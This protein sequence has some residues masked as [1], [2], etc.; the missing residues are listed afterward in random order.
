VHPGPLFPP[1]PL[2]FPYRARRLREALAVGFL[3]LLTFPALVT[4]AAPGTVED[5]SAVPGW[6]LPG[7]LTLLGGLLNAFSATARPREWLEEPEEAAG[8]P[9]LRPDT[10]IAHRVAIERAVVVMHERLEENLTLTEMARRAFV[11]PYHFNRIFRQLVGIPPGQFLGALRL[12]E[13]KRLLV[14]TGLSVT[15]ICFQV[16]YSSLGTFTRRFTSLVGFCPRHFRALARRPPLP[17]SEV[18]IGPQ[19]AAQEAAVSGQIQAAD[20]FQGIAFVG[21]FD[22]PIPQG[23]PVA[24]ALAGVPGPFALPSCPDGDFHLLA[25]GL[26]PASSDLEQILFGG[27]PRGTQE[28]G[29]LRIR[30]GRA[31]RQVDVVLRQPDFIDPP[32]LITPYL[33]L[34][35]RL[36]GAVTSGP[37]RRRAFEQSRRSLPSED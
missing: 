16:G 19:P 5:L 30:D 10:V 27:M 23:A 2:A 17:W 12:Q 29:V 22:S 13:A 25:V 32:I 8:P 37:K 6:L 24:C 7:M 21:L 9:T 11:S 36:T 18:S 4:A 33:F 31:D 35:Q 14:T 15:D 3:L 1:H 20:G 34:Q 26:N 28:K